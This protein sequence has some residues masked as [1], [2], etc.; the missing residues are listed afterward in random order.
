MMLCQL[1]NLFDVAHTSDVSFYEQL[2]HCDSRGNNSGTETFVP[3]EIRI[4]IFQNIIFELP[5][6]VLQKLMAAGDVCIR[7]VCWTIRFLRQL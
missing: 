6:S 1:K 7:F 5:C 4:E 3:A 2:R